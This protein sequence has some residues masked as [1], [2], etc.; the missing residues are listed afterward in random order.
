MLNAGEK[1]TA[2]R[3]QG[4]WKDVG[5]IDSLW[6]ANMDMLSPDNGIDL[7]DNEWPIYA[8]TPIRPPHFMGKDARVTHSMVTS[9]C[10]VYGTV[11]NSV[12]FHSVI[13]EEGAVVRYSILMPGTVV[14]KGAVVE[15]AIVAEESVIGENA[16]VG[17][18][19]DGS[20][21]WGIAVIAQHLSIGPS[22]VVSP[23]AMIT[24]NV[25]GGGVK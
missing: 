22:A 10:E 14:K 8:R 15:Y 11:E 1:M 24:R 23:K 5:T 18:S 16:R 20:E 13:V 25:K 3:F 21:D 4:Y 2:Y 17:A 9:G 6:D 19:P 12:L 7:Y